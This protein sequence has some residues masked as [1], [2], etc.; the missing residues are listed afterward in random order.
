M[1]Q[2]NL[3]FSFKER[4]YQQYARIGKSLSSDKRLEILDLLSNGPKSVESI[5]QHSGMTVAN[6]SRHLQILLDAQLVKFNKKGNYVIYSLANPEILEFLMSLWKICEIQLSDIPRIKDELLQKYEDVQTISKNDLLKKME[7]KTIVVLDIRSKDEYE[8]GHI[9][10]AISVP[11]EELDEYL[12]NLPKDVP[13][14]AYCKGPYCVYT[15]HA[16]EEMLKKG[17]TAYRIEEG[18]HDLL[19]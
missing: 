15:T 7:S 10:G 18:I 3:D 2:L 14:A 4:L 13:L 16:V 17:F 6:V 8:A 19:K 5:S 11:I 12:Q 9:S 1:E